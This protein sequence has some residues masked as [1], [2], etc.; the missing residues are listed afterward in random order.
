MLGAVQRWRNQLERD[1]G[2]SSPTP[3]LNLFWYPYLTY[4][5]YNFRQSGRTVSIGSYV[6]FWKTEF[7]LGSQ[8]CSAFIFRLHIVPFEWSVKTELLCSVWILK[9]P[10]CPQE[11][12]VPFLVSK[13]SLFYN[14]QHPA[15]LCS[16][17]AILLVTA[18][19]LKTPLALCFLGWICVNVTKITSLCY[20]TTCVM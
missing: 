6:Y 15:S 14:E 1:M 18:G 2:L 13:I 9:S 7:F 20:W 17:A 11:E 10:Q 3:I 12:F 19:G 16:A 8:V 5:N 4:L